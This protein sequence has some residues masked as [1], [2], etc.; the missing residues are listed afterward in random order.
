[1]QSDYASVSE[2]SGIKAG[3]GG[4]QIEVK[5]NT[6]LTGG[7]ITSS[8][9]AVERGLNTLS[10]GTLTS[11]DIKNKADYDASS[12][13]LS[14]GAGNQTARKPDN[15]I[16]AGA[17]GQKPADVKGISAN[18][19][20]ALVASGDAR[21]TTRS[22]ISGANVTITNE[23]GQQALTG[24]TAAATIA[25]INTDVS[26]EHDG[27]N[28][29][30][31]IFD[32][33]EIQNNFAITSTFIQNTGI[34]L[35]ERAR[36]VDAKNKQADEELE[37][38][39]NPTLSDKERETHIAN[40]NSLKEQARQIDND[41]G[42]GGTYRQITVALTA[43]ASANVTGGTSQFAQNMLVNYVQ[44]EGSSAIG[45]MVEKGLKEGSPEHAAWHAML[46][47]AGAAASRQSCSAG[48]M[49]GAASSFLTTFFSETSAD[50]SNASREAKRNV[51]ASLVTGIA[52]MTD[53]SAAATS[54]N[55]AIANVD[56][57]WLATQQVIQYKK[58]YNE[59][60]TP[61]EKVAV[62]LKWEKT[63]LDQDVLTGVGIA[64]GFKDGMAGIGVDTLNSAVS[65][66]RD[67]QA[68]IDAV[69]AFVDSPEVRDR[70]KQHIHAQLR[71]KLEK[72]D[73]ALE[74]GGD[75]NAEMLGKMMG[76]V[77]AV[78]ISTVSTGGG[79]AATK[80]ATLSEMGIL[81]SGK[82]L[83]QLAATVKLEKVTENFAQAG[84]P[85][86]DPDVP[87]VENSPP[88]KQPERLA[89]AAPEI[90]PCCFAA[91]TKVSTPDGDRAIETLKIGDIVW[92]KPEKGGK[93][94]AATITATHVRNDQPIYRLT[95]K[96]SDLNGKTTRETLLVTPGHPFY[97]PAQKDFVPVIDLKLG[98]RLQSLADGATE[99]TSSE[100]E[101]LELY[102]PVGTTYN[103]TVDVGHTF[104]VGDLKTWVHNT[105]PC[106]PAARG[107]ARGEGAEGGAPLFNDVLDE[108][109]IGN[110]TKGEGSGHKVD[111]LPNKQVVGT[112]GEPIPVHSKPEG[113]DGPYK[114]PYA[115]QEFPSTPVAHGFPDIVDNY[116]NSATKFPLKNGA[117]LY[118]ASGS[119]NGVAGRF[120]WIVDPKLGGVTHRM[121]V[122]NGTVNGIPVKP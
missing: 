2:Q 97:V 75:E 65:M 61:Q 5:G 17:P 88:P 101:S 15:T 59:A 95:L 33:E 24:Q 6:G 26:S 84:K 28:K 4:F 87:F 30:K 8:D 36:E 80:S 19:P 108:A 20:I 45:K 3:D 104:Y 78:V 32:A 57:N 12:I 37:A 74:H 14:G 121:F 29:L 43:G 42:S 120:E 40:Y 10:T 16:E 98:D 83:E 52:A 115:T 64:K 58:E 50:E 54:T 38:L 72:I 68:H 112:D 46:G 18:A 69:I 55:A 103:L 94:F 111:Q 56:N 67:P 66:L 117:S 89:N 99:N 116:A 107:E 47:C 79:G 76:E 93:P 113:Y 91:G 73:Q 96:G 106:D 51:I 39:K 110:G 63:S 81:I 27:S 70:L 48:A 23:A 122:P 118:Q 90:G 22:G 11:T 82:K 35:E 21:S 13:G 92:S 71:E 100:V 25:D 109:R 119:Y 77:T 86:R 7:A 41:W 62:F 49:G 105:G 34:Y 102:A 44:Q 114:G 53:P 85:G 31:P 60:K 1:M 9:R